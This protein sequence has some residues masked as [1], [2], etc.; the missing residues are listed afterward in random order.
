MPLSKLRESTLRDSYHDF[1]IETGGGGS[2]VATGKAAML[3]DSGLQRAAARTL[4]GRVT[5]PP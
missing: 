3:P 2:L 4:C 1:A 5:R